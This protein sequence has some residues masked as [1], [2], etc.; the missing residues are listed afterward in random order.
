MQCDKCGSDGGRACSSPRWRTTRC[1]CST[2]ARR[3]RPRR[4]WTRRPRRACPARRL[5]GADRQERGRGGEAVGRCPSCGLTPAQF[6][7]DGPAGLR[8]LLHPLRAAPARAAAAAARRHPARRQGGRPPAP[9]RWTAWRAWSSLRRSLQRAVEA[10]DFEHAAAAARPDPAPRGGIARVSRGSMRDVPPA[11][12]RACE[13]LE[14][15]G[16]AA[17]I[18]LST[19]VRLA[20]NLRD[21]RFGAARD[22]ADRQTVLELVRKAAEAGTSPRRGPRA[23]HGAAAP[24]ARGGCCWS[25]TSSAGSWWARRASSPP[26][27]P[28][29]SSPPA[30]RSE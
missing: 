4:A 17:D 24:R 14:A 1:R 15:D 13:W 2:C 3:A 22:A 10:E 19:R 21:L 16:P 23:A 6:K 30:R 12:R 9:A 29:S 5:P 26:P 25:A 7:A 8:H 27:T 28:R 20:R 18:V 11:R